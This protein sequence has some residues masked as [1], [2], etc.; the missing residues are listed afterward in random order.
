M[1]LAP[2]RWYVHFSIQLVNNTKSRAITITKNSRQ[3][4]LALKKIS[5]FIRAVQGRS[6]YHGSDGVL[7]NTLEKSQRHLRKL[8]PKSMLTRFKRLFSWYIGSHVRDGACYVCWSFARAYEPKEILPHVHEIARYDWLHRVC[9][10]Y[11][12]CKCS[13][14][15]RA[16]KT[17]I[18][19]Q[20]RSIWYCWLGSN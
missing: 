9:H 6:V 8:S 20:K 19:R 13:H 12:S 5:L 18:E 7:A 16:L 1:L 10:A 11:P 2:T 3:T 17:R 4:C 15:H 14:E